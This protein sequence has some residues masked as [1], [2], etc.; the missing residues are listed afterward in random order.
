[1]CAEWNAAGS[2]RKCQDRFMRVIHPLFDFQYHD[3]EDFEFSNGGFSNVRFSIRHYG[4]WSGLY[5]GE[6]FSQRDR[7][8]IKRESKALV[9]EGVELDGFEREV[10]LLLIAFRILAEG[11]KITPIIKYRLSEDE[12]LRSRIEETE[13]H[14]RLLDPLWQTYVLSDFPQIDRTFK[15]LQSAEAGS[16]RLKNAFYFLYRAFNSYQWIDAFMFYMGVIESLFSCDQ[17][18]PASEPVCRRT[19]NLLNDP[20]CPYE[21]VR[22]L[23]DVR[24]RIIHGRLEART[25]SHA[26]LRLTADMEVLVK[27]CLRLLVEMDALHHYTDQTARNTFLGTLDQRA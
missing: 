14:I 20:D 17:K 6:I 5:D 25:N 9:A 13:M 18:G 1:M 23:Y 2:L 12:S 10:S 16:D 24:S 27:R 26:N 3:A 21:K 22:D 15:T 4:D 7:D 8:Y 19:T 11:N